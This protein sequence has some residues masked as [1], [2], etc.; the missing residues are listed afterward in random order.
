MGADPPPKAKTASRDVTYTVSTPTLLKDI[1]VLRYPFSV[2]AF[3]SSTS[4]MK[5]LIFG[6][7]WLLLSGYP[8]KSGWKQK[9]KMGSLSLK[10]P[11][12]LLL[13]LT[14]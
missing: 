10:R 4:T 7:T 1:V 13:H 11:Q 5:A 14:V 9:K 8:G 6:H 3:R 2:A 12:I